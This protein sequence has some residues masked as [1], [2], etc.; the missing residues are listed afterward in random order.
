V[1]RLR[2]ACAVIL[3]F[4]ALRLVL[5]AGRCARQSIYVMTH[6]QLEDQITDY[7]RRAA[8]RRCLERVRRRRAA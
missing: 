4:C 5:L 2:V 3:C 6:R 7:F 8:C 1:T